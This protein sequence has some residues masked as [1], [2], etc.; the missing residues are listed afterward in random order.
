M[1]GTLPAGKNLRIAQPNWVLLLKGQKNV[2]PERGC[3]LS[4]P[5][6]VRLREEKQNHSVGEGL[7]AGRGPCVDDPKPCSKERN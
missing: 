7:R 6:M 4:Q 3:Q 1:S 2:I 5:G